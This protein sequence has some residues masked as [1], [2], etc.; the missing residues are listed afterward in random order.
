MKI[1]D[2]IIK[3]GLLLFLLIVSILVSISYGWYTNTVLIGKIDAETKE[4][5]FSYKLDDSTTNIIKY[6]VSNLA[7]FDVD[8]VDELKYF[9]TMHTVITIELENFSSDD[10]SYYLEFESIKSITQTNGDESSIAYV[11]GI[12]SET[13][14]LTITDNGTNS[15]S[16]YMIQDYST[17]TNYKTRY[18]SKVNLEVNDGSNAGAR[19]TIYLHIFGVQEIDSATNEFLIDSTGNLISYDFTLSIHSMPG[20]DEPTVD[21]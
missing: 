15:I 19:K 8:S 11:A 17:Q 20:H 1:F 4:V 3:S 5:T 6:E 16:T 18:D 9:Q 2:R 7:F 14:N 21:E 10:V 12:F 13:E